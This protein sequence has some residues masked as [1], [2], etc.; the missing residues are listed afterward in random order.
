MV[1]YP[2]KKEQEVG[3]LTDGSLCVI[4]PVRS[5]KS[6]EGSDKDDSSRVLDLC[7]QLADLVGVFNH[8]QVVTEKLYCRSGNGDRS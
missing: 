1:R 6:R 7:C 8:S 4:N 3:M 2:G 5:E